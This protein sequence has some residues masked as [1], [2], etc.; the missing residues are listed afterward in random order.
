M[1]E[2]IKKEIQELLSDRKAREAIDIIKYLNYSKELDSL[3]KETI[4]VMVL[5]YDLYM[6]NHGR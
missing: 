1:K 5:E 4:Q 3:I 2:K 6:T